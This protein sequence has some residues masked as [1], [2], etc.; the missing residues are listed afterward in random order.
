M[1]GDSRGGFEC[2]GGGWVHGCCCKYCI[3]CSIKI[4]SCKFKYFFR[5]QFSRVQL[6]PPKKMKSI[7]D[8]FVNQLDVKLINFQIFSPFHFQAHWKIAKFFWSNAPQP[9]LVHWH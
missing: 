5:V 7:L 1:V 8:C 2:V 4:V 3:P 6:P 9:Y